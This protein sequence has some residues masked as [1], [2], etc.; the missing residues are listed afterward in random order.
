RPS[1]LPSRASA[2]RTPHSLRIPKTPFSPNVRSRTSRTRQK[3]RSSSAR[4]ANDATHTAGT[5]S[6]RTSPA[7]AHATIFVRLRRQRHQRAR[8]PPVGNPHPP[9]SSLERLRD[10]GGAA[11]HLDRN[12]HLATD[13]SDEPQ[14]PVQLGSTE[15]LAN[16]LTARAER[17]P[18]CP[19]RRPLNANVP[20]HRL[21]STESATTRRLSIDD[22]RTPAHDTR[23]ASPPDPEPVALATQRPLQPTH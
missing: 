16:N 11:Q 12:L 8:P 5:R 4:S 9:A 19:P 2:T 20:H 6:R 3:S 7:N 21:L 13:R 17:A 1:A 10:P 18:P 22:Q 15:P 14:H 23:N